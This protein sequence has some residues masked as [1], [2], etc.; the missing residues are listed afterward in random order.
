MEAIGFL[1]ISSSALIP[2]PSPK[3]LSQLESCEAESEPADVRLL[4][5]IS[6][7][8]LQLRSMVDQKGAKNGGLLAL[9]EGQTGLHMANSHAQITVLVLCG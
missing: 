4:R 2:S 1:N 6:V 9:R 8:S 5:H 7:G 3:T